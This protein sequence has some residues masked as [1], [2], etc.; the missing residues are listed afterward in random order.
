VIRSLA[1]RES[2]VPNEMLITSRVE[3]LSL[4]DSSLWQSVVVSVAYDSDVDLV[5]RLLK[6]CQPQPRAGFA[7]TGAFGVAVKF[8]LGWV[9][10]H[11]GLLD[12]RP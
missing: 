4:A 10:V 7:H 12:C 3:N 2:I 5:M 1:G 6:K 9:G 11:R 8:W